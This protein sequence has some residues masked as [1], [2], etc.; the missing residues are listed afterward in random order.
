MIGL[1]LDSRKTVT[2]VVVTYNRRL[3]LERCLDTLCTQDRLPDSILVIDN[4]STDST[5]SLFTPDAKW[6]NIPVTY[7]R[8]SS[9]RGGAGGFKEGISRAQDTKSDWYWIMDDDVIASPHALSSLLEAADYLHERHIEP[10]FLA[11]H[12]QGADNEVMNVPNVSSHLAPNGYPDWLEHLPAG[13]VRIS[14][15]TF[16][17]LL[18]SAHAVEQVGLPIADYFLWGDDI[19]YTQRLTHYAGPAFVCG[20]SQVTHLR[21]NARPIEIENEQSPDRITNHRRRIRNDLI[22]T[23]YYRGTTKA[24]RRV[25]HRI[26]ESLQL[27]T[28]RDVHKMAKIRTIYAGIYDYVTHGYDL[29]DLAALDKKSM[30]TR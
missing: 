2:A 29:E 5:S 20:R 6:N 14:S 12:V 26:A 15:A 1:S 7:V 23:G 18:I 9:N 10:S 17:S 24:L 25:T 22:T 8:L 19:E 16:V 13:L 21:K 27:I 3:L 30:S 28:S 4:A 11:S